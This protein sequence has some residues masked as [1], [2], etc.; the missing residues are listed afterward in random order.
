MQ[1][2]YG[3][4]LTKLRHLVAVAEALNLTK[5]AENLHISQPALSRSII[6]IERN[7][8]FALFDRRS[9]GLALTSV[10]KRVVK[11]ARVVLERFRSY[12]HTLRLFGAG[13]AGEVTF[14]MTP[15]LASLLLPG[16]GIDLFGN[17]AKLTARVLVRPADILLAALRNDEI[18]FCVIAEEQS[19][20]KGMVLNNIGQLSAGF[21]AR[22]GHPLSE[23]DAVSMEDLAQFTISCA[24]EIDLRLPQSMKF[25]ML[26]CDNF[27]ILK[28]ISLDSD[29]ICLCSRL[30][31]TSNENGGRLVE[32]S[33]GSIDPINNPIYIV[34]L[35]GRSLSP[36]AGR[37]ISSI[38][39]L[40]IRCN[41]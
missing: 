41:C 35:E 7:Y 12:E 37:M 14:G 13:E 11:D 1:S 34:R 40:F 16:V 8:G 2:C 33:V 26:I 9:T 19:H 21:F 6:S 38:V 10:G 15:Q 22:R 4:T 3:L 23:H 36:V 27:D 31:A 5:A 39:S 17:S 20:T 28:K 25:D 30:Y 18:E 29:V 24:E 32:I